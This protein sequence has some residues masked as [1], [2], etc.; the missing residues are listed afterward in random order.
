M[1]IVSTQ[2]S[3]WMYQAIWESVADGIV[4]TDANGV[5]LKANPAFAQLHHQEPHCLV[6]QHI[7]ALYAAEA[8]ASVA[9]RYESL[10][11]SAKDG[12]K[13]FS[14]HRLPS[15]MQLSLETTVF[16]EEE[17]GVRKRM[18][19]LVREQQQIDAA[20]AIRQLQAELQ[21][22]REEFQVLLHEQKHLEK[23]LR[24]RESKASETE[25][26]L[27][28]V[29]RHFPSGAINVLD[30]EFRFR[31][32][33]GEEYAK[34]GLDPATLIGRTLDEVFPNKDLTRSKALYRKVFQGEP[35]S[36][37]FEHGGFI[38][39][40]VAVPLP[41]ET[42]AI[43][44]ILTVTL[45]ITERRCIEAEQV[46]QAQRLAA[47]TALLPAVV[48]QYEIEPE[49]NWA[50]YQQ[51]SVEA[52]V[53]TSRY[54]YLSP[55]AQEILGISSEELI[56]DIGKFAALLLPEELPA[57]VAEVR[58]CAQLLLPFAMR[59]R[60]RKP[61]G[62]LRW[63]QAYSVPMRK[64]DSNWITFNGIYLDIT[65]RKQL[66]DELRQKSEFV[67]QVVELSPNLIYLYD[68]KQRRFTF[69]NR[70]FLIFGDY[71]PAELQSVGEDFFQKRVHPNDLSVLADHRAFFESASDS[72]T[73][74]RELRVKNRAG[75]WRWLRII[76]RVFT[77]DTDGTVRRIIGTAQDITEQKQLELELRAL[78]DSLEQRIRER[79]HEL[80]RSQQLYETIARN[81][82]NGVLG[83][84]DAT[85][86]LVFTEGTEY[87][88]MGI[89]AASLVG[90]SVDAI[91]PPHLAAQIKPH[92]LRALEG[93][94][95]RFDLEVGTAQYEYVVTPLPDHE[96]RISQV[97]VVVQ[98]VTERRKAEERLRRSEAMLAEAQ[99]LA[100]IG[101]C[102]MNLH[103][104]TIE[105]SKETY[106]IFEIPPNQQ[107]T[108]DDFLKHVHPDDRTRVLQQQ[109]EAI[110]AGKD[111]ETEYRLLLSGGRIKYIRSIS[112]MTKDNAGHTVRVSH[113]LIDI[114]AQK[115]AELE[116][117]H[118][119]EKML[120]SQR[121]EAI[122]T[123]ASG[124]AHEFNNIMAI[125]GLANE[126][127]GLSAKSQAVQ[128]QVATIRKS[129]ER[130]A[131]IARQLLDFSRSEKSEMQPLNLT[132]VVSDVTA[133]LRRLLNKKISV[134]ALLL[135]DQAFINGNDKQLYQVFLNLGINAGD[136]M[137]NGGEL[138][139]KVYTARC[140]ILKPELEP[141]VV[142]EVRDTGT[143]IPPEIRSRIFEPFFT[144]KGL[145]KGTGLGLAI[146]HGF[147][148]AHQG[149]IEV[150]SE[151]GKG[152]TFKIVLPLLE[153]MLSSAAGS[154][155]T[156]PPLR[157]TTVMIVE[158]ESVLR[159]TLSQLLRRH[160]LSVIEAEDGKAALR[161]FK[162]HQD[163]I[164]IVISDMGM[165]NMDGLQLLQSL[166]KL[167]PSLKAIAMTGY[168]DWHKSE[169]LAKQG[170]MIVPKPFETRALFEAIKVLQERPVMHIVNS[171]SNGTSR[172]QSDI[173]GTTARRKKPVPTASQSRSGKRKPKS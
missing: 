52:A 75:A 82:P 136:A 154:T 71:T 139:F 15:G 59:F 1:Q 157:E 90:K 56:A 87:R 106:R 18:L 67:Q 124:I 40:N 162:K 48:Y 13:F 44:H 80:H 171:A 66:E 84:Y 28:T 88:R 78:N 105:W 135:T 70:E 50:A 72:D 130:G 107:I 24:E 143:G 49:Q 120:A 30:K 23:E 3:E 109:R 158:D 101:S 10:F 53:K 7:S 2:T 73:F 91:Y 118:L 63:I 151:V 129:I 127:I 36:F 77:R 132:D 114:T 133:T 140:P 86:T 46:A 47:I 99:A 111:Y 37:E 25:R 38:Y 156:L 128:K 55:K 97:M 131:S 115:E 19:S 145:G 60:I 14:V 54:T 148:A 27:R 43:D 159:K 21:R 160:H 142:V 74:V 39:Q 137:P 117:Q 69:A 149:T 11:A 122:G 5:I 4:L 93:M 22:T 167:R 102:E 146:V 57:I 92:L 155:P 35:Q 100:H 32:A 123:L 41:S 83:I 85:L 62:E 20:D 112:S 166:F 26:L 94:E 116:R 12:E 144:T 163:E 9:A 8:Q 119:A 31:F 61:N 147:V 96:G 16:F 17:H 150:E 121:L 110:A 164:E 108:Y 95:S 58:R 34:Y 165:P 51:G 103:T 125:I 45:N 98:N 169:V 33:D 161:L 153:Q 29:A 170:V 89:P 134:S 76:H 152:T 104:H 81:F 113:V 68:V 168:L 172:V 141:A 173:S 65:E 126:Q 6:G 79:T 42:G 64:A 138:E